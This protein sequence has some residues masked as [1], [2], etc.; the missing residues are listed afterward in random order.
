MFLAQNEYRHLV[1]FCFDHIK[2]CPSALFIPG[3]CVQTIHNKHKQIHS[4]N[5]PTKRN[6]SDRDD[7]RGKILATIRRNVLPRMISPDVTEKIAAVNAG[8]QVTWDA[9]GVTFADN[10][11][12]FYL[13]DGSINDGYLQQD[14]VHLTYRATHKLVQHLNLQVK[15]K[16]RGACTQKHQKTTKLQ[17]NRGDMD[18]NRQ[19]MTQPDHHDVLPDQRNTDNGWKT[20][21]GRRQSHMSQPRQENQDHHCIFCGENGHN[22]DTCR[23]VQKIQC[24]SCHRLGHKGK[25][26]HL[27]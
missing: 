6:A 13:R 11:S 12:S 5:E 16:V 15:D 25:L 9:K 10:T 17:K 27:F 23:H 26:C 21:R 2:H 20:V 3:V 8:I 24:H 4:H 19:M 18:K 7:E 14:G 1:F 22:M